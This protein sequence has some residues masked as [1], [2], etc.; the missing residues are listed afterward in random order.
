MNGMGELSVHACLLP[1]LE[2]VVAKAGEFDMMADDL[3]MTGLRCYFIDFLL[4]RHVNVIY[5][6][7]FGATN[8]IMGR[9]GGVKT[10]LRSTHFQFDDHAGFGHQ[11]K[12]SVHRSQTYPR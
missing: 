10:F 11:L 12:I 4:D 3:V 5:S 7:A 8:V 2:A 1:G 6:A 9:C